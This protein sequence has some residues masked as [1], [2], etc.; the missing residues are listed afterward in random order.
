MQETRSSAVYFLPA[1]CNLAVHSGDITVAELTVTSNE[2]D[3]PAG[4][5]LHYPKPCRPV[6]FRL[7]FSNMKCAEV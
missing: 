2:R 1:F 4:T 3:C 5:L 7:P 6:S